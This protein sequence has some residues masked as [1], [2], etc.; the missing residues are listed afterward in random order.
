MPRKKIYRSLFDSDDVYEVEEI[1]DNPDESTDGIAGVKTSDEC[2]GKEPTVQDCMKAIMG[3][4]DALGID[5]KNGKK[6]VKDGNEP[7][8]ETKVTEQKV[9]IDKSKPVNPQDSDDEDEDEADVKDADDEENDED[10]KG[11]KSSVKDSYSV[12][13]RVGEGDKT[14]DIM[15]ATQV[16]FQKRYD[17]VANK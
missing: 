14:A 1:T 15:T 11:D 6:K 4:Y 13:A 5:P 2:G 17:S 7:Q 16:A 10:D 3:L 12:F 9:E 8:T